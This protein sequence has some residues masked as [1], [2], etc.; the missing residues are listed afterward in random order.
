MA[1]LTLFAEATNDDNGSTTS[2]YLRR[3]STGTTDS[4][5]VKLLT[6]I[7]DMLEAYNKMIEA[8]TNSIEENAANQD[9]NFAAMRLA[10]ESVIEVINGILQR[11]LSLK[12]AARK[13]A[14][15]LAT[16]SNDI[17]TQNDLTVDAR[18][19][20]FQCSLEENISSIKERADASS[21]SMCIIECHPSN[22][23]DRVSNIE[24][25]VMSGKKQNQNVAKIV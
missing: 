22:L 9:T 1:T 5:S 15:K 2:S 10:L 12:N 19:V 6:I 16:I 17:A 8:H 24:R 25:L 14:D 4:E 23:E 7:T 3:Q 20:E 13:N 18:L 21:E 11:A